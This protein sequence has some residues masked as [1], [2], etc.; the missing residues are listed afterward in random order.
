ME[1]LLQLLLEFENNESISHDTNDLIK[2]REIEDA[3]CELLID[4]NG[5]CNWSNISILKSVGFDVI[6]IEKD[7][8]GWLI[9]GIV[10]KKGIITYG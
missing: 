6:P 4:S 1:S 2:H 10:T 8:F 7:R 9:G 5:R 3:A